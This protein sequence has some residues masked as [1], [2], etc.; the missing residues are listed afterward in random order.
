MQV[1]QD[2][3]NQYEAEGYSSLDRT[4]YIVPV[5]S[6]GVTTTSQSQNS[7][8]WSGDMNSSSNKKFR[9]QPSASKVSS[10]TGKG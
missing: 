1:C 4:S 2:L 3:L 7:S 5:M 6:H 10:G 8:P 9:M